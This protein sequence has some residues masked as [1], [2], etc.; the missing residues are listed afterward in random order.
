MPWANTD[1]VAAAHAFFRIYNSVKIHNMNGVM[2]TCLFTLHACDAADFA[3]FV[4]QH[5]LIA[6]AA[7][8]HRLLFS[9]NKGD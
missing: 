2:L 3:D 5:T 9:R 8:N 4:G 6:V 7:S 1:T